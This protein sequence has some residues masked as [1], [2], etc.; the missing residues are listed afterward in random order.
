M[1]SSELFATLD[2][3]VNRMKI[4]NSIPYTMKCLEIEAGKLLEK[5]KHYSIRQK[6]ILFS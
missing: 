3:V 6:S 5:R 1:D 4:S 2:D